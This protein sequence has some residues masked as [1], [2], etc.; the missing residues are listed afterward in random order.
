MALHCQSIMLTYCTPKE[1]PIIRV[2]TKSIVGVQILYGP[3]RD[4]S[5]DMYINAQ[6]VTAHVYIY[7]SSSFIKQNHLCTSMPKA[8]TSSMRTS[9]RC[10]FP[11]D[12]AATYLRRWWSSAQRCQVP[13]SAFRS[14]AITASDI[15][16]ELT[17]F[18]LSQSKCISCRIALNV[19]AEI[20][21]H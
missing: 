13:D 11:S 5:M 4:C 6:S 9:V 17:R 10:S 14:W 2:L 7:D 1:K 8:P 12:E 15:F 21:Q 3:L 20:G 19:V 18:S 16:G